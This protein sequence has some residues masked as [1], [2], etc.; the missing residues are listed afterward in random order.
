VLAFFFVV[1]A[2]FFVVLA[3]VFVVL[4]FVF[5][6]VIFELAPSARIDAVTPSRAA[7]ANAHG[8]P[9]LL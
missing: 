3:F 9:A 8:S 6:V 5:D 4:A 2:F 7:R 1:L